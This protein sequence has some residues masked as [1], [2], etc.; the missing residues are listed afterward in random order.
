[1]PKP[2][3]LK[4]LCDSFGP[5]TLENRRDS[6]TVQMPDDDHVSLLMRAPRGDGTLVTV[7]TWMKPTKARAVAARLIAFADFIE[8]A[9]D[10][11]DMEPEVIR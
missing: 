7:S 6:V 9:Q 3:E 10:E 2:R 8:G 5:A 11:V 1:M 4:A